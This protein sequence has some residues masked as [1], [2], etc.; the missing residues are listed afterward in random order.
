M[1]LDKSFRP[2]RRLALLLLLLMLAGKAL[3]ADQPHWPRFRG[4]GGSGVAIASPPA[5]FGLEQNVRWKMPL[6]PGH[7]S[8]CISKDLL[9]LT[10]FTEGKLKAFCI[11]HDRGTLLWERT[12]PAP[13]I[14]EF[15][16]LVGSPA[17][18]TPCTDGERVYFYFASFG[19]ICFDFTGQELW[20]RPLPLPVSETGF[21]SG[22]SPIVLGDLLVLQLDEEKH[23]RLLA[24]EAATGE[25]RWERPRPGYWT[26]W[27]TPLVWE[28]DGEA[29]V[30]ALGRY[31]LDAYR[32]ADGQPLWHVPGFPSGICTSP[33]SA[34]D[35]LFVAAWTTSSSNGEEQLEKFSEIAPLID[36]NHDQR[37]SR[38]EAFEGRFRDFFNVYDVDRD[39]LITPQEWDARVQ[40][41]R[42]GTN[43]AKAIR[44]GTARNGYKPQVD[45]TYTR[46]LPYVSSPLYDGSRL[47]LIRDGGILSVLDAEQGRLLFQKRLNAGGDYYASPLAAGGRIYLASVEGIVTVLA[48]ADRYELLAEIDLQERIFASP[49]ALENTLLLRTEH[50]L[51]AFEQQ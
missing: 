23:S 51:Y 13:Q 20:Q 47:W 39:G 14:E 4:P 38:E 46:S 32:L 34:G 37:I 48:A 36:R 18:S 40:A 41:M 16:P 28:G 1:A 12:I 25:L 44:P 5:K 24:L 33:V 31:Q 22:T 6:P 29:Q 35:R 27:S 43:A 9:F 26:S 49:C 3:F 30:I 50:H 21:G 8:P 42:D 17:A 19:A 7:S 2:W 15:H 45:W 11:H 10:G